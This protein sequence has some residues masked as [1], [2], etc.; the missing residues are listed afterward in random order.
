MQLAKLD[1]SVMNMAWML[2]LSV[3]LTVVTMALFDIGAI[4][5][6]DRGG[7]KLEFGSAPTLVT[8]SKIT[9]HGGRLW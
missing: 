3:T 1:S 6:K 7:I 2:S 4:T 5:E 9:A 8:I